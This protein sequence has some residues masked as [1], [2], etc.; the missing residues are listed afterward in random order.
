MVASAGAYSQL[1]RILS[2]DEK[3]RANRFRFDHLQK[4]FVVARGALRVLLG[5]YLGVSPASV[6]FIYGAAGKPG[7]TEPVSLQFNASHS[8]GLAVF[9]FTAGCEIGVDVEQIRPMPDMQNI[10]D[11]FFCA[12]E[13]AELMTLS[14]NQRTHA[15]FLCWTR[16]EAYIKATGE[17]LSAPLD[18][19]RVT[20]QPGHSA[21]FIHLPQGET[22]WKLHD[23]QLASNYTAALAYC[24][25]ERQVVTFPLDDPGELLSIAE[26]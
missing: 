15:F 9:A 16:K 21:R 5:R 24:D 14:G 8:G 7:L 26:H 4:S 12:E 17:G 6:Q 18:E 20:L 3:E 19:F 13:A 25:T 2:S 11:R 1:E 10:A 22:G 23:L